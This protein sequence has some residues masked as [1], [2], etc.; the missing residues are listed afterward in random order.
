MIPMANRAWTQVAQD[1]AQ[2]ARAST[3]STRIS[4]VAVWS[5]DLVSKRQTICSVEL[6]GEGILLKIS[7][8]TMTISLGEGSAA[9]KIRPLKI[10]GGNLL[11]AWA[12]AAVWWMTMSSLEVA[13]CEWIWWEVV[14]EGDLVHFSPAV[15]LQEVQAQVWAQRRILKT[16]SAW[17]GLR[18]LLLTRADSV[19]PRWLNKQMMDVATQLKTLICWKMAAVVNRS[20][21]SQSRLSNE[22][23]F[24]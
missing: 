23:R 8:E 1:P 22:D 2:G 20:H 13:G 19:K 24:D 5:S 4:Q 18:R 17:R 9:K 7:S 15:S 21:L 16:E 14:W 11:L 3:D 10:R 12:L 6:S